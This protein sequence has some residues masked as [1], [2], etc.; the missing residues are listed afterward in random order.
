MKID[1]HQH[2]LKLDRGDYDWLTPELEP[3][4]RDFAH[5]DLKPL[6]EKEGIEGTIVVQATDTEAETEYLFSLAQS[7]D[8][9]L[10]V[11]VG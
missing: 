4:Y 8:W 5:S 7:H 3:I 2:F 9:I 6:L 1:S 11:V 10:G